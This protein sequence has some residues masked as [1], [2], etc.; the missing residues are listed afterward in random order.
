MVIANIDNYF[1]K[2]CYERKKANRRHPERNLGLREYHTDLQSMVV[3]CLLVLCFVCL[4]IL[5]P[6]LKK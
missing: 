6:Q 5:L 3:F 1:N 4:F 2:L